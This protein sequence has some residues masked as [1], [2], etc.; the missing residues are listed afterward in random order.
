[1]ER[2]FR[3]FKP[4]LGCRHLYFHTEKGIELQAYRAIIACMLLSL[5][6]GCKP[7]NAAREI[8]RRILHGPRRDASV[9]SAKL[10]V[11]CAILG[12]NRIGPD[13]LD[14]SE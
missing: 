8:A 10:A 1:M 7:T 12:S 13:P 3:F 6:T 4:M 14:Y 5:W 2:F 11:P 9:A